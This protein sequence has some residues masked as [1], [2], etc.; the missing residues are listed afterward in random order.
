MNAKNNQR[1]K[2]V[3]IVSENLRRCILAFGGDVRSRG[4]MTATNVA[5]V[6][7]VWRRGYNGM[8]ARS[9]FRCTAKPAKG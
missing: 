2:K 5:G 7:S 6:K 9:G 8:S 4:G 3:E 1:W